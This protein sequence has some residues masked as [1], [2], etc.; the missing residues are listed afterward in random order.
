MQDTWE[1]RV[2][3]VRMPLGKCR[4]LKTLFDTHKDGDKERYV[5]T[6]MFKLF[7]AELD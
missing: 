1:N 6:A 4:G 2:I 7:S 5:C 3:L